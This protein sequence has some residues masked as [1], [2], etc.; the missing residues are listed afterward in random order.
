MHTV[1]CIL[2]DPV[3][4]FCGRNAVPL[5]LQWFNI[6][7][8]LPCSCGSR[9][10][11][12]VFQFGSFNY[13][14]GSNSVAYLVRQ[15]QFLSCPMINKTCEV[16]MYS[17]YWIHQGEKRFHCWICFFQVLQAGTNYYNGHT[18][19]LSTLSVF[20]SCAGSLGVVFVSLQVCSKDIHT[21]INTE[22]CTSTYFTLL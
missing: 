21:N 8:G 19:Q 2:Y 4:C 22:S 9:F 15:V 13:K 10:S 12:A 6:P 11:D 20:L 18:G 14:Q 1:S 17:K 5:G 7:P 16:I 3:F